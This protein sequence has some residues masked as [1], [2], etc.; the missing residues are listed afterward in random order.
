SFVLSFGAVASMIYGA[1]R[2]MELAF[3]EAARDPHDPRVRLAAAL[4]ATLAAGLISMPLG[5]LYFGRLA[6][7]SLLAN[8]FVV[9]AASLGLPVAIGSVL[10][11]CAL[12]AA[13]GALGWLGVELIQGGAAIV[14][15]L[16]DVSAFFARWPGA[17]VDVQPP[18]P[19]AVGLLLA[20]AAVLIARRRGWRWRGAGLAAL[21][22]GVVLALAPEVRWG[23]RLWLY[24]LPVGQGDATLLVTPAGR[25]LLVD[26]AGSPLPERDPGLEVVLPA[27]RDL[28][29][30]RLEAV[31][32]SHPDFDHYGGLRSVVTELCPAE[33]WATDLSDA[34]PAWGELQQA[35][36]RCGSARRYFDQ[37]HRSVDL[38]GVTVEVLHPLV[39][40]GSGPRHWPEFGK[41]DNSLVLRLRYGERSFLLPGDLGEL[42]EASLIDSRALAPVDLLKC[43]HHGSGHSSTA[44]WLQALRPRHAVISAGYAN[45]FGHPAPVVIERLAAVGARVWRTDRQGRIEVSTDGR[46]LEITA[47]R[48]GDTR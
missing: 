23:D 46:D 25:A 3:G 15:A 35:L 9:P 27:L 11:G 34:E 38:D 10:G 13:G 12:S 44:E 45:R 43:G 39:A 5:A 48:N 6:P 32:V 41:N 1:P 14:V 19:L 22:G 47:F 29:I 17:L 36:D 8:L 7:Y 26:T 24:F 30:D 33:V 21:V 20:G 4:A 16:R 28:G 37:A 42:G 2:L 40:A 18:S 31:V